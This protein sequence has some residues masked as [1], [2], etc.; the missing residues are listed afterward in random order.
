VSAGRQCSL[1]A[2]AP[3]VLV[4]VSLTLSMDWRSHCAPLA[5]DGVVNGCCRPI[6]ALV[7]CVDALSTPWC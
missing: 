1:D 4:A 7:D 3:V 6:C 5:M 2:V